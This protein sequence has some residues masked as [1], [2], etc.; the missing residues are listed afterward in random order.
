[1]NFF[2]RERAQNRLADLYRRGFT[3]EE[4]EQVSPS[5][6]ERI[7]RIPEHLWHRGAAV[8]GS[9]YTEE[10]AEV[11]YEHARRADEIYELAR[12]VKQDTGRLQD[13][14]D[15]LLRE[16]RSEMDEAYDLYEQSPHPR[17]S[18]ISRAR[19]EGDRLYRR[20]KHSMEKD[21]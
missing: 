5:Y 12:D 17:E 21:Y 11:P 16:S 3:R 13:K 2:E 1:V 9:T 10:F 14:T 18:I 20:A 7:R 4:A 19:H 8:P 15:R 6:Y